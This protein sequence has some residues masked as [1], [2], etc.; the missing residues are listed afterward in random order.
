MTTSPPTI[1]RIWRGRTTLA[2]ADEYA[3]YLLANGLQPLVDNA[4][5]VQMFRENR[6]DD[7]EFVTISWWESVDAMSRFAGDDPT[8]IHH[9]ARDEEYLIELPEG[10]QV[11]EIIASHGITT[12]ARE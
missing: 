8:R 6:E 10:V 5:A 3:A 7:T 9:L 12:H 4:L 1:A 11:L 2:M